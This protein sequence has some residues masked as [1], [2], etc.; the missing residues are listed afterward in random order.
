MVAALREA[1][2]VAKPGGAIVIQVWGAHERCALEAMKEIARPFFPPRPADAPPD[3]DLSEPGRWRRSPSPAGLARGDASTS[4]LRLPY[5]DGETL[6]RALVAPAGSPSRRPRARGRDQGSDRRRARALPHARRQLSA[7]ERVPIPPR[8]RLSAPPLRRLV[9]DLLEGGDLRLPAIAHEGDVRGVL[10]VALVGGAIR[11]L[12]RQPVDE[13]VLRADLAQ[14]LEGLDAG[15][16]LGRA[17]AAAARKPASS[18]EPGGW[19][20]MN[21]T[22]WRMRPG[23]RAGI[24]RRLSGAREAEPEDEQ[25]HATA[26]SSLRDR[27]QCGVRRSHDGTR[28]SRRARPD[29]GA[30]TSVG[31]RCRQGARSTSWSVSCLGRSAVTVRRA[32]SLGGGPSHVAVARDTASVT[33]AT[34]GAPRRLGLAL[35]VP[36]L[37][38]ASPRLLG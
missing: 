6:G 36:E 11:E 7:R 33:L 22:V 1:G 8:P 16:D 31:H 38:S 20:S 18:S 19:T 12:H 17:A 26:A 14:D 9:V 13:V 2:R 29:G 24:A 3:P 4:T 15:D 27:A 28:E 37:R 30:P 32:A 21:E 10:V 35:A 5:A 34:H 23:V 25:P